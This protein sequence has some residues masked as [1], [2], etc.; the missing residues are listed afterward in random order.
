MNW[1]CL[2]THF[3]KRFEPARLSALLPRILL[4]IT[5]ISTALFINPLQAANNGDLDAQREL[6]LK[7]EK[8]A[9]QDKI[10]PTDDA[11]AQLSSYPLF[12]Y[13]EY[14][15]LV[16]KSGGVSEADFRRYE[17]RFPNLHLGRLLRTRL[18]T[19]LIDRGQW[20]TY[21]KYYADLDSPN[22]E[23]QCLFARSVYRAGDKPRAYELGR[24]L[25]VAGNSQPKVCD[26]LFK[27][28]RADSAIDSE[29]ALERTLNA[30]EQ[31]Q[32]G[33]AGYAK[34]FITQKS[35]RNIAEDA[36]AVYRSPE[37]IVELS[38]GMR[39][40]LQARLQ[41]IAVQRAY[42]KGYER[43]LNLLLQLGDQFN[44]TAENVELLGKVGVRAAKE[45]RSE[46]REKLAKLDPSYAS[47]NLTEW[48]IRLALQDKD[49][50]E[51]KHLITKL[52]VELQ[53]NN[54]WRYWAGIA[55]ERSGGRADFTKILKQR[56]F[57]GFIAAELKQQPFELN[58]QSPQF[59]EA[60]LE[61]LRNSAQMARI[62]ELVKLD[63]YTVA[64]S[65]W[66][67]WIAT[68]D[69]QQRQAAA[70]LMAH[71]G[72]YQMGILAAAY[73]GLWNDMVLRFPEAY[74]ELFVKESNQRNI[75]PL[76]SLAVSRQESA[77][78][79]WARSPVGARGLMQLMP[80]TAK[81]TAQKARIPYRGPHELYEAHTNVRLGTAY[82]AQM[83]KQFDGNRAYATAA[84][85]AGPHRV[86]RWLK[87]REDLPLDIWIELIPFDETR[88]YVQNVLSF[89]VIYAQL[90]GE[91][92]TLFSDAERKALVLAS[93]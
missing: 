90:R 13:L 49:W 2:R 36:L 77:L 45:L 31:N 5:L 86:T 32:S 12:P 46:D 25:W 88:T 54:R 34:R 93:R 47:P 16:A 70:R 76:W 20:E 51:V 10:Q 74:P 69:A 35:L 41:K 66:N 64:R 18:L 80:A 43:A 21:A 6:F 67:S 7:L 89:R 26:P 1:H 8:L 44:L 59:S 55:N 9:K 48:R 78:F 71:I 82:L 15:R 65:E 92:R 40:E 57:Y 38:R 37:K 28:M 30:L 87:G 14:N 22:A 17:A 91:P 53:G 24:D 27:E 11:Y 52:P 84:Y 3:T 61:P 58:Q 75:D 63:R 81:R 42:R 62:K 39:G 60:L 23:Q 85:N 56:S 50:L 73:E 29:L 79:P 33:L 83:A 68:L 72:W 4:V 19:G